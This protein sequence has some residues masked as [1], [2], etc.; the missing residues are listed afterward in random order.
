[1]ED[2]L[3]PLSIAWEQNNARA[4]GSL[5]QLGAPP[6]PRS[7]GQLVEQAPYGTSGLTQT[8]TPLT[9]PHTVPADDGVIPVSTSFYPGSHPIGS[10][11]V[12]SS[13]DNVI[14][15]VHSQIITLSSPNAFAAYLPP[16]T[17]SRIQ[18]TFAPIPETAVILN[19]ILHALYGTS[20]A[21]NSPTFE[22]LITAVS[23]MPDYGIIAKNYIAPDTPLYVQ[24]LAYAPLFPIQ[25]YA[26]AARHKVEALAQKAS[27]HLLGYPLSSIND[28][29]AAAMGPVYLKRLF[30]LHASRLAA[31][32]EL[33]LQPPQPHTP[34]ATCT[35]KTQ[36]N[37][38]RTW[39]VA[40]AYLA[41]D[42]RPDL[43]THS[44]QSAFETV[45]NGMVCANCQV[46]AKAKVRDIVVKWAAFK[47]TIRELSG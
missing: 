26:F 10:D 24:L 31:L 30:L 5:V 41:W 17:R 6:P 21:S 39:A 33:L 38:S 12:L 32:K 4:L 47:C 37:L 19:I 36:K 11:V 46:A 35:V 29:L 1:M 2:L 23:R 8:P 9:A 44:I 27:S 25:L 15:Y 7:Q 16:V 40:T 18:A 13:V 28:E 45:I 14:F 43:S 34:T 20:S 42:A 22:E 3:S